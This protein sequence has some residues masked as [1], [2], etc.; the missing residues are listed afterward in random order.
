MVLDLAPLASTQTSRQRFRWIWSRTGL[1]RR[2]MTPAPA[3]H[4]LLGVC[5]SRARRW[6]AEG[7]SLAPFTRKARGHNPTSGQ[8]KESVRLFST[9]RPVT[10]DHVPHGAAHHWVVPDGTATPKGGHAS[11][12]QQA[13]CQLPCG[14]RRS[15]PVSSVRG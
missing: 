11:L 2:L 5:A 7:D 12:G 1:G 10:K 13:L 3:R 14:V 9:A 15:W 6:Q 4:V 8:R